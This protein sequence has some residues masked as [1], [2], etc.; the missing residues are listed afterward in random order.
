MS[1]RCPM[2][3]SFKSLQHIPP[4]SR[5]PMTDVYRFYV[6][7]SAVLYQ[8]L[9]RSITV[10]TGDSMPN[11]VN[12]SQ[13]T[14]TSG[15]MDAAFETTT[16][17]H[18][19]TSVSLIISL[20]RIQDLGSQHA[21][22]LHG[23]NGGQ[24]TASTTKSTTSS[25]PRIAVTSDVT[26]GRTALPRW[27]DTFQI[28]NMVATEVIGLAS[29]TK[30]RRRYQD[31]ELQKLSEAQRDLQLRLH[32]D[33]AKNDKE[34]RKA[35]NKILHRIKDRCRDNARR[36]LDEKV[37][38]IENKSDSARMYSGDINTNGPKPL[39]LLAHDGK[40]I[41]HQCTANQLVK[42]HIQQLFYDPERP[43]IAP[44]GGSIPLYSPI[45]PDLVAAVFRPLNN[46]RVSGPDDIPAELLK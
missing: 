4:T 1:S 33:S 17:M 25:V 27:E 46:G 9:R 41:L 39:L 36:I 3:V 44:D 34:L 45:T 32:N 8:L 28:I 15:Y 2:Q 24:I 31:Q 5:L 6:D 13:G 42:N 43:T 7:V 30:Q 14:H 40:Y 23:H 29:T 10:V 22:Y 11:S 21:T 19:L 37:A 26:P 18:S 38:H 20:L 16:G 35:R 12:G